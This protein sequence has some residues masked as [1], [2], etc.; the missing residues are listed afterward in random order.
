MSEVIELKIGKRG[1]IY[2]TRKIRAKIGLIPGGKA[3]AKTEEDR[4]IVQPK[5]TALSLLEKP[6]VNTEPISPDEL[7]ELRKELAKEIELR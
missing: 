3:I 1:E 4:L 7:S 2:T 5:G 6:R